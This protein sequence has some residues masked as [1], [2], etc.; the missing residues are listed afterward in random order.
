[1]TSRSTPAAHGQHTE[2]LPGPAEDPTET[3]RG[4]SG[5]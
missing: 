2:N 3:E 1:M 5:D 4:L